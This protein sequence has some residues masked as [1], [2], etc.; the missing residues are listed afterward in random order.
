MVGSVI[1]I[2]D[3]R[4][5]Y[6]MLKSRTGQSLIGNHIKHG[7]EPPPKPRRQKHKEQIISYDTIDSDL[8]NQI[9]SPFE[10]YN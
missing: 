10:V 2:G 5:K 6:S 7:F 4:M 3:K 8:L 1:S 9:H